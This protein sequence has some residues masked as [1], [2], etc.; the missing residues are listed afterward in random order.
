MLSW[1]KPGAPAI[2]T[3]VSGIS[4]VEIEAS[5]EVDPE[6]FFGLPLS[7]TYRTEGLAKK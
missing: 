6:V 1:L 3:G 4:G 7:A 5:V 2:A